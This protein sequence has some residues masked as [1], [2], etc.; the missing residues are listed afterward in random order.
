MTLAAAASLI[1]GRLRDGRQTARAKL[2]RFLPSVLISAATLLVFTAASA[3]S[4]SLESAV[5]ATYLYKFTPFIAWPDQAF[6][7]A[8]APFNICIVGDDAFADMVVQAAAG[9][10]YG[11]H[12]IAVRKLSA[13]DAGCQILYIPGTDAAAVAN[14]LALTRSKPVLTVTDLLPDPAQTHGI[15]VFIVDAG[16]VRFDIDGGTAA[17]DGLT[18]SSKLLSLSRSANQK[19]TP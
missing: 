4:L 19:S 17:Q 5:K 2:A 3:A 10:H 16:H 1:H 9:Q 13:P 6:S 18:I 12:A 15:V 8:S 14:A 7:S 11:T